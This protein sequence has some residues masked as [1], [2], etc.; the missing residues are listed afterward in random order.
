MKRILALFLIAMFLVSVAGCAP[1]SEYD[2]LLVEKGQVQKKC[3]DLSSTKVRLE[4]Q[5]VS[6]EKQLAR[7]A[8]ALRQANAKVSDLEKELA[9][10]VGKIKKLEN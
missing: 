6:K 10:Q 8:E 9:K 5:L 3:N 4:G 2:K 1:K 7:A